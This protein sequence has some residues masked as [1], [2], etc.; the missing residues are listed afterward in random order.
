M[1]G[2]ASFL[3]HPTA[4]YQFHFPLN[5]HITAHETFFGN[6]IK[7]RYQYLSYQV[8]F[9]ALTSKLM[10][11]RF[12]TLCISYRLFQVFFS[13]FDEKYTIN[14]ST[15][16]AIRRYFWSEWDSSETNGL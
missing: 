9:S 8:E 1:P 12:C 14:S 3:K 15:V 13:G 10:H 5:Q 7:I 4:F 16:T 11:L 6:T 2:A